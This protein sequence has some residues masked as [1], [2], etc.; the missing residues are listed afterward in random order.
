MKPRNLAASVRDRLLRIARERG[1]DFQLLLTRYAIERLLA[2]L[3]ASPH[4]GQFILKGATLFTVWTGE[5]HRATRDV[6]LLGFGEPTVE[7]IRTVFASLVDLDMTPDG[8]ELDPRMTVE[9]IREDQE[10]GG[11][12]VVMTA[13]IAG[14]KVRLQV[15]VGFG[16]AVTPAPSDV[17]FPALLNAGPAL[18]RIPAGDRGRREARGARPAR[19][20]E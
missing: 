7:R 14:A 16:D 6:D 4:S 10:Y 13:R 3:A 17:Q 12:R 5:P 11:V 1:E 9:P 20:R 19:P 18:A 15:D 8:V 2:R